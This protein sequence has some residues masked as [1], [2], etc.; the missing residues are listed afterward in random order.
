[1]FVQ[2]ML[3]RNRSVVEEIGGGHKREKR[4]NRK[5]VREANILDVI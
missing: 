2:Q 5:G 3:A 1:M 4:L